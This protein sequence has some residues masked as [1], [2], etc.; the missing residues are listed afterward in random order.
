MEEYVRSDTARIIDSRGKRGVL[1]S[2]MPLRSRVGGD[3]TKPLSLDLEAGRPGEM[4]PENPVTQVRIATDPRKG[5][6][7]GPDPARLVTIVPLGIQ[8]GAPDATVFAGQLLFARAR[9]DADLLIRPSVDGV[10]T[11]EQLVGPTAPES[12]A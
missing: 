8:E 7:I 3:G 10:Q 11:F 4:R 12:F 6:T 2:S 5:F 1:L 9:P